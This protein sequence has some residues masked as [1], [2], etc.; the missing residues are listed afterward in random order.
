[1]TRTLAR[2]L[3]QAA[4]R[5]H[6]NLAALGDRPPHTD[7]EGQERH[8]RAVLAIGVTVETLPGLEP[9]AAARVGQ[10][11]ADLYAEYTEDG[12]LT[13]A[14]IVVVRNGGDHLHRAIVAYLPAAPALTADDVFAIWRDAIAANR[15]EEGRVAAAQIAALDAL[16]VELENV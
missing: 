9:A 11:R 13:D 4:A 2:T 8:D 16:L 1:M 10:L 12:D 14:W 15:N 6:A 7:P 5:V 3:A